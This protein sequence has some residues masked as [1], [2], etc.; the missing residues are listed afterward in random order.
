MA[1]FGNF[2]GTTTSEFKIGKST[3]SKI[4]TG[5]A[6]SSGQSTGDIFIDASNTTLKVFTILRCLLRSKT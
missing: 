3:G 6:P 4:S 5:T 2:K 1:I